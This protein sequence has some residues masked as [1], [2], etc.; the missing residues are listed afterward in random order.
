MLRMESLLRILG[1][2]L[3]VAFVSIMMTTKVSQNWD[4]W[5]IA[6]IVT[7]VIMVARA[8]VLLSS[9]HTRGE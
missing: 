4:Y 8:I 6:A 5:S 1:E 7:G 9:E 3:V 2:L